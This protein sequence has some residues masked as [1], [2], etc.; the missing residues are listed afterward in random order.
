[1][2]QLLKF[3]AVVRKYHFWILVVLAVVL[4]VSLWAKASAGLSADTKKRKTALEETHK[5]VEKITTESD[6]AN[7]EVI[8]AIQKADE[9]LK[10]NV[11]RA[12]QFLYREQQEKNPWPSLGPEFLN[13][14]KSLDLDDPSVEIQDFHRGTYGVYMKG[15]VLGI[16]EK[17]I[18]RRRQVA[19]DAKERGAGLPPGAG[20]AAGPYTVRGGV[21]MKV[22][23]KVDWP[24]AE[25]IER[26]YAWPGVIPS[27][28]QVRLAQEDLWVY[29][30]LLRI[31]NETNEGAT[32]YSNAVVKTIEK[33]EIGRRASALFGAPKVA[34]APREKDENGD[35]I[36][37][38]PMIQAQAPTDGKRVSA[39]QATLLANRYLDKEF[40]P[41][42]ATAAQPYEQFRM[43]PVHLTLLMDQ[44]KIPK[45]LAECGN[46]SMPVE[47]R[48]V[49]I[50]SSK[51]AAPVAGAAAA[52]PLD[53]KDDERDNRSAALAPAAIPGAEGND[54][55]VRVDVLGVI[56]IFA[57]PTQANLETSPTAPAAE[58]GS[59][60]I[61]LPPEGQ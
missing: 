22:V 43:M 56:Y 5:T 51:Q 28:L 21:P 15:Q 26:D 35:D 36:E 11:H 10:G 7:D 39:E 54:S 27:T 45:L 57:A 30:A 42:A 59:E 1:M 16:L 9:N 48:R 46:C 58:E 18:D 20:G 38:P 60:V 12:W 55:L 40:Q 34:A 33:L 41:L 61:V 19:V 53:D 44:K 37:P 47:V 13:H 32:D 24:G 3:L 8:K 2:D 4:S 49:T 17:I 52:A 23:G 29:Q 25:Q 31:V 14:V 50:T 6:P